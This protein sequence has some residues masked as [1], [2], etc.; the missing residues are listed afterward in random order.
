MSIFMCNIGQNLDPD[1]LRGWLDRGQWVSMSASFITRS[2][3]IY[4]FVLI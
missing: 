4:S 1:Y 2:W 3:L